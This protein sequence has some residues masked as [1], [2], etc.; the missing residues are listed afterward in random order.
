MAWARAVGAGQDALRTRSFLAGH[1]RSAAPI[2][3]A[4]RCAGTRSFCPAAT[5][6]LPSGSTGSSPGATWAPNPR[7]PRSSVA[8]APAP[9]I[10]EHPALPQG[11]RCRAQAKVDGTPVHFIHVRGKEPNPTPLLVLHGCP[12]PGELA[13][14]IGPLTDP[15]TP[16]GGDP[17]DP[18]A[19]AVMEDTGQPR[20]SR[21]TAPRRQEHD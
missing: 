12:W 14:A 13:P 16:H 15:A 11:Q 19:G 21:R 1:R 5:P 20:R 3:E 10:A 2:P 8:N 4:G 9:G 7:G 6:V 17:A 18:L